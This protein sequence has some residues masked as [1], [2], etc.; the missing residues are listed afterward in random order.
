MGSYLTTTTNN[1]ELREEDYLRYFNGSSIQM[2]EEGQRGGGEARDRNG[3]KRIAIPQY[4][5]FNPT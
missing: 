3:S 2:M 5:C 1:V 4:A